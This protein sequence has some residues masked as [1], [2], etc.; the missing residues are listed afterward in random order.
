MTDSATKT[1]ATR[2]DKIFY[3][4]RVLQMLAHVVDKKILNDLYSSLE[5]A[6]D[7][8]DANGIEHVLDQCILMRLEN[9]HQL[10]TKRGG[11]S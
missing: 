10:E 6:V 3:C 4:K 1:V 5:A 9:V 7:H 8:D 11:A 2:A